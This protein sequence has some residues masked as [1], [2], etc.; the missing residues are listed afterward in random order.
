MVLRSATSPTSIV[1]IPYSA[2]QLV[3]TAPHSSLSRKDIITP[4]TLIPAAIDSLRYADVRSSVRQKTQ[5]I[6]H[7]FIYTHIYAFAS[8]PSQP[9]KTVE[10]IAYIGLHPRTSSHR[11]LR[12]PRAGR[13]YGCICRLILKMVRLKGSVRPLHTRQSSGRTCTRPD[14]TATPGIPTDTR[15]GSVLSWP[16]NPSL[17]DGNPSMGTSDDAASTTGARRIGD[18]TVASHIV[19]SARS[20]QCDA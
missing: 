19:R 8:L 4:Y 5:Q 3:T 10:S 18:P 7:Y 13:S 11:P 1:I 9:R 2:K 16:N 20:Q 17:H 6:F 15:T 12:K 14:C